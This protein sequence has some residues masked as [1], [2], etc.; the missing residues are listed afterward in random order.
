V[1]ERGWG[2]RWPRRGAAGRVAGRCGGSGT[3]RCGGWGAGRCGGW[4]AGRCGGRGTEPVTGQRDGSDAGRWCSQRRGALRGRK[5]GGD[6][7]WRGW[8][9]PGRP[10]Q[11]PWT[12]SQ[13]VPEGQAR[14]RA[15][16]VAFSVGAL[17]EAPGERQAEPEG[18]EP[19][20]RHGAL[21]RR[22]QPAQHQVHQ[23]HTSVKLVLRERCTSWGHPV[24]ACAGSQPPVKLL[25]PELAALSCMSPDLPREPSPVTHP[26]PKPVG[27]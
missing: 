19:D 13:G 7:R 3:W 2:Q 16:S 27:P 26:G 22:A 6:I 23:E 12:H 4:G 14:Q 11:A 24:L 25:S 9:C 17:E 21:L 20:S 10:Q 15:P 5:R 8:W 18:Q 1:V